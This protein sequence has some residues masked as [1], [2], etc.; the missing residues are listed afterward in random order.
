MIKKFIVVLI[1]IVGCFSNAQQGTASPYSFY[2]IGSLKFRGT[3]EN[4]GMGGIGSYIDS[5]HINLRNPASYAGKTSR[6]IHTTVRV[7]QSNF[8]FQVHL[9]V[10][11]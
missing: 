2:G 5:L 10:Q 1:A 8:L 4:R 11:P 6:Q 7:D 3:A 9:V